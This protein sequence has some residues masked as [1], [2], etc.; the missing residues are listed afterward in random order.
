MTTYFFLILAKMKIIYELRSRAD[1]ITPTRVAPVFP[2]LGSA[3]FQTHSNL[4]DL[5]CI[6]GIYVRH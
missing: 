4:N 6:V 5:Q 2:S 3:N 1:K